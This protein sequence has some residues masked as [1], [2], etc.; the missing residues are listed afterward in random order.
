MAGGLWLSTEVI[1]NKYCNGPMVDSG[2]SNFLGKAKSFDDESLISLK[3]SIVT[4]LSSDGLNARYL[5]YRDEIMET[6]PLIAEE[7]E[8]SELSFVFTMLAYSEFVAGNLENAYQI[9]IYTLHRYKDD[10][11]VRNQILGWVLPAIYAE[12]KDVRMLHKLLKPIRAM[13]HDTSKFNIKVESKV[14]LISVLS[15]YEYLLKKQSI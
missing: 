15:V 1:Y 8:G 12:V 7:E 2:Y 4:L 13:A 14:N 10:I 6:I 3:A 9:S 5:K 11:E